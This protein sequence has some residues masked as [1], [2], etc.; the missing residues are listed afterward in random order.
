MAVLSRPSL[1][2][3]ARRNAAP[4]PP[5]TEDVQVPPSHSRRGKRTRDSSSVGYESNASSKKLKSEAEV[6]TPRIA[7]SKSQALKFLPI[8]DRQ[9]VTEEGVTQV[10]RSRK[11]DPV[12]VQAP[13]NGLTHHGNSP[14]GVFHK[15]INQNLPPF[16]NQLDKRSL[17]SHDGCSRSKSELA[18]YFS[19]YDELISIEPQ[20]PGIEYLHMLADMLLTLLEF[21]TTETVLHISDEPTKSISTSKFSSLTKKSTSRGRS[22]SKQSDTAFISSQ[23]IEWPEEAFTTLN[24]AARVDLSALDHRT[25]KTTKDPLDD[26]VYLRVHAREE[27]KEKQLRNIEKERAMHEKVQLER[28]LDGLKGHDWL[29]V[30]GISGITDGEKKAYEPKRDHLIDEVRVLLEKFRLWKE[31]EKRRKVE[32]E[33]LMEGEEFEGGEEDEGQASSGASDD[34]ISDGDPPDYSDVDASAARQLHME[35]ILAT[36]AQTA[37]SPSRGPSKHPP[38]KPPPREKPFTSFYEKP[39]MRAAAIGKHRR[40]GRSRLAF[41]QPIPEPEERAFELPQEV[42]TA[43]AVLESG[44]RKRRSRWKSK[45][46]R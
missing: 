26:S 10:V 46:L 4:E 42:R 22:P 35:A 34:A 8:R 38:H 29:R 15:G 9:P 2:S 36:K 31:E 12:L 40:S 28:L 24:N 27:R 30:M 21:L 39:Y 19:N 5:A 37:Q 16:A 32:K 1:R 14:N 13:L 44:R 45:E 25:R 6:P 18:P 23:T 41:G 7:Q 33:E 17:R 20:R 43:G 11:P 3:S